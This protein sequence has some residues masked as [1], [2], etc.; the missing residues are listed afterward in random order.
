MKNLIDTAADAGN[1][2]TLLSALSA[3]AL[4]DTLRGTGPF[5]VFAPTDEAFKKLPAGTLDS[6]LK[7]IPK[8]KSILTYHVAAGSIAAK[9]VKSGDLKTL[10][11]TA[12]VAGVHGANVTVNGAKVVRADIAASNGVIHSIDTVLMPKT[13]KLAAVA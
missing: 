13:Q 11:G 4:T 8:L 6:L 10:E 7:D 9:D 1:F 2:S 12:L 3:A 5:T